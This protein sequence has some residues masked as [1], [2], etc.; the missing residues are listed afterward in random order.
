MTETVKLSSF[1]QALPL[2]KRVLSIKTKTELIDVICDFEHPT[3]NDPKLQE[4]YNMAIDDVLATL[5][6]CS[7]FKE[8]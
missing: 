1:A 8:A 3:S 5:K 7:C 2:A 6:I 4:A